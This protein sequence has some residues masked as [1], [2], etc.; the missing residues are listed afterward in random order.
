MPKQQIV[1]LQ[2][3]LHR[4]HMPASLIKRSRLLDL[5]DKNIDNPLVLVCAPAG[6]GKTTL[7][8][9]W[10]EN[11]AEDRG[12]KAAS[13][14]SAWI[15]LD[16]NDSDLYLF[17]SYFV[18]AVRT[19]FDD[20]CVDT[21][22]L[23]EARQ[24]TPVEVLY[25][26]FSN[27][28][29]T[30]PGDLIVVLDDY[31]TVQ[32]KEVHNLLSELMRHWPKPLHLVLIS[33]ISPPIPLSSFR[34][35]GMVCEIRT[36]DLRFTPEET[37]T[38]LDPTDSNQIMQNNLPLLEERFEGW[39][40]G[41]H[42]ATLSLRSEINQD[43]FLAT[44]SNENTNITGYLVDEVLK[45]QPPV[46]Q[47]FLLKTSILD[48]FCVS[49]CEAVIPGIDPTWEMRAC[50]DWVEQA[51][52]FFI[53]LDNRREWYR[54]HHL[55]QDLLH[56]RLSLEFTADRVAELH[57]Q[58]SSWFEGHELIEEALHHALTAGDLDLVA[59]L[60]YTGMRDVVNR[61]DRPTLERWQRLLTDEMIMRH[62]ELLMLKVWVLQFSWRL[63]LQS[64]VIEQLNMLM[65]SA[66]RAPMDV[67][68]L[69]I[70]RG[71]TLL[72]KGQ[73]AYFRNQTSQSI[74][75][76]RQVL[77]L[78]P[79]EWTFVRGGAM[80]Y[81]GLSLQ[82][83]GQSSAAE[84]LLLDEFDSYHNK[85]DIFALML[86]QSLSLIYLKTNRLDQV[87][88]TAQLLHQLADSGG[89]RLMKYWGDWF[90]GMVHYQRDEMDA[91][92]RHFIQIVE[93]PY[94]AHISSYR[95]AIA[96]MALIHQSK[97][98]SSEAQLMME[99][100][101]KLDLE[102]SGSED[103]RTRSL[104]ARLMLLQGNLEG[105]SR[106]AD[107]F[108]DLPPDQP[109]MWLEEPQ[110][111]RVRVLIAKGKGP[112]LRLAMQILDSLD[113]ITNRT[114]NLNHKLEVLS[115]RA[116]ALE[117]QGESSLAE[118]AI[119]EAINLSRTGEIIRIFVDLGKPMQ[120]IIQRLP[121][122]DDPNE[123]IHRILAAFPKDN[124]N[125]VR[126]ESPSQKARQLTLINSKLSEP[127]TPR[128][129]EILN[130][131]SGPLSMKEIARELNISYATA[132][133]HAINLY[134]KL[135]VSLRRDAVNR[136]LELGILLPD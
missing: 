78:L 129:L 119:Q 49:L 20:A 82:A 100:I 103:N 96:G 42:L 46:I 122:Q 18:A 104:H 10:L 90:L 13:L 37:A 35:K 5:L 15:S 24:Q 43:S 132:K 87:I 136:A 40:A 16:E 69:K 127:L 113:E 88:Q 111:T 67:H 93:N 123:M 30:L 39:P 52:L 68:D 72:I 38:Y 102:Q 115:L 14:P 34:A 66:E 36:R 56:R 75:F 133:R 47:T 99:S 106:W 124:K 50:L 73:Y 135:D 51:E 58:A 118:N 27:D 109:L 110:I 62:P 60:M 77:E 17:L 21:L 8:G 45:Q 91:A 11:R 44:L 61:E 1:L 9:T 64:Q 54:Y 98:Q 32:G 83:S 92:M 23:L 74:D 70:L 114:H 80:L 97:A 125:P 121:K 12:A 53:P 6:F 105:A 25:T 31:H 94:I 19:I 2:T 81:L 63:H 48:R 117:A 131:L 65:D 7:I 57:R 108:T 3:K 28:L 29:T 107:G 126:I 116:L 33:R 120:S 55:F 101:I 22:G 26:T 112:D 79:P 128:E 85:S 59:H 71:Q 130:L 84:R 76:C 86:L 134:S 89:F 4:P 41:L 95:D